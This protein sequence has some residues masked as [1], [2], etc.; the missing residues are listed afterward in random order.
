LARRFKGFIS[1]QRREE[2]EGRKGKQ[3]PQEQQY[4]FVFALLCGP[5]RSSRLC[6][7]T[8]EFQ[9]ENTYAKHP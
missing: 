3:T 5:L 1:P 7:E 4:L 2:R 6:G 9:T 8:T